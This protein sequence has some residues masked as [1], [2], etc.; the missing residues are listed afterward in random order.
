MIDRVIDCKWKLDSIKLRA[1][2][3]GIQPTQRELQK[4]ALRR[5]TV[6]WRS[7]SEGIERMPCKRMRKTSSGKSCVERQ[8]MTAR[9]RGRNDIGGFLE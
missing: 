6:F 3:M 7:A 1:K 2:Y 8:K 5:S 9:D 4:S